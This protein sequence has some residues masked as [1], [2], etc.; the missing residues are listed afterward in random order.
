M[1]GCAFNC[2]NCF[3]PETHDFEKGEEFT[4]ET[5]EKVLNLSNH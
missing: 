4:D 1:Q 5:I 2:K 3:N